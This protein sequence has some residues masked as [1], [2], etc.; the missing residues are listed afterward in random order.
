MQNEIL[1]GLANVEDD[2][3]SYA[4]DSYGPDVSSTESD[5]NNHQYDEDSYDEDSYVTSHYHSDDN[6]T[7]SDDDDNDGPHMKV[8]RDPVEAD[9]YS[10]PSQN[11]PE[12]DDGDDTHVLDKVSQCTQRGV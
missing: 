11:E 8:V 2:D 3:S 1:D 5:N 12:D 4:S 7:S 10:I 6:T 9:Q